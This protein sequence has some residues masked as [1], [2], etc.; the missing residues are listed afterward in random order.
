MSDELCTKIVTKSDYFT[1]NW[2]LSN[3]CNLRCSYCKDFLHSSTTPPASVK[4]CITFLTKIKEKKNDKKIC[5]AL[6]GGEPTIWK[7]TTDLLR[8]CK[9]LDIDIMLNSNGTSNINWWIKNSRYIDCVILSYH[10]EGD[11]FKNFSEICRFCVES[12]PDVRI[13]LLPLPNNFD[14]VFDKAI[15]LMEQYIYRAFVGLRPMRVDFDGEIYKYTDEQRHKILSFNPQIFSGRRKYIEAGK[16]ASD[17]EFLGNLIPDEEIIWKRNSYINWKCYVGVESIFIELDKI[18]YAINC[19]EKVLGTIYDEDL[20]LPT[21]PI[22]C[23]KKYC[24]CRLNLLFSKY[25]G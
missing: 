11:Y 8:E 17:L 15:L 7:N 1:I 12:V 9:K 4:D 6:T 23:E 19:S 18:K 25:K 16:F 22:T 13:D 24:Q 20:Q 3:I 10:E 14:K 2:V 5:L 21:E